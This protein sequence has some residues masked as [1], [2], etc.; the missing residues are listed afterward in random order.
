MN[1][2]A[3]LFGGAKSLVGVV[4]EPSAGTDSSN[5]PNVIL[6]NAGLLHRIG[7]NRAYVKLIRRLARLG[8]TGLRFDLS[9]IGD[10]RAATDGLSEPESRLRDIRDAMD[11]MAAKT[12]EDRF[13]LGG[14]C[15][16]AVSSFA[17]AV[18]DPRV[19]GLVLIDAFRYRTKGYYLR[20][21]RDRFFRAQSWLNLLTGEHPLTRWIRR[22]QSDSS[23]SNDRPMDMMPPPAEIETYYEKLLARGVQSLEMYPGDGSFNDARQFAEM[24]PAIAQSEQIQLEYLADTNHT[25]VLLKH[26]RVLFECVERWI[27]NC[28]W[29]GGAPNS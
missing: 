18:Q 15:D 3:M 12:G 17:A 19:V 1:E 14:L 27:T 22:K 7:P 11:M 9:G 29:V 5:K 24:F 20:R 2:Q 28:D 23:A 25:F 6:L 8:F 26:Q 21:Y 16:G 10:S 13:I 4:T